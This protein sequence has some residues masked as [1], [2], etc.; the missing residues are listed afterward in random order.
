MNKSFFPEPPDE[1]CELNLQEVHGESKLKIPSEITPPL[2]ISLFTKGEFHLSY[3]IYTPTLDPQECLEDWVHKAHLVAPIGSG[4]R[5]CSGKR[6][7]KQ[8]THI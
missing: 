4:K 5:I 3:R 7:A 8:E 2:I 6:S 1:L